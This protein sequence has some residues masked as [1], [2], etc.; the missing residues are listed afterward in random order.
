MP[1]LLIAR[2]WTQQCD[3]YG[4]GIIRTLMFLKADR[5]ALGAALFT[6]VAPKGYSTSRQRVSDGSKRSA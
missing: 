1:I 3:A 2:I 5:V 6:I 4:D